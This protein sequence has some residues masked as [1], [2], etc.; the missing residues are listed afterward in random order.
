L[1]LQAFGEVQ[2]ISHVYETAAVGPPQPDYLNA[3]VRLASSLAPQ[4]LLSELLSIERAHGRERRERWGPR[5]LDLDLLYSPALLLNEADLTL[6]H[7]ELS[8]RAFALAPL[9]D[10]APGAIDPR[11]GERYADLFAALGPQDLRRL[12]T[13]LSWDPRPNRLVAPGRAE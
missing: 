13:A 12:E 6:P 9:L 3:A 4:R 10:V 2:A 11:S 7:P 5:T 8:R 1:A